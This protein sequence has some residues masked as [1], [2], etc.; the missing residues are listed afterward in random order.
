VEQN[1]TM[2]TLQPRR[3]G[4]RHAVFCTHPCEA[5][6][7]YY[8]RRLVPVLHGQIVDEATAVA[9][10]DIQWLP[11][12][13]RQ[14]AMILEVDDYSNVLQAVTIGYGRRYAEPDPLL[15]AADRARQQITLIT[16]TASAYTTVVND[17]T[18]YRT[19]LPCEARTYELT[20][21][22]PGGTGR[23]Q[24]GDFVQADPQH[25][26]QLVLIFDSEIA[27]AAQPTSGRQR[28]LI[29]HERTLYRNDDCSGPLP[30]AQGGALA[31]PYESYTLAFTPELVQAI[32]VDS[33]KLTAGEVDSVLAAEGGDVHSEGDA[34][35]WMPSGQVF[36]H[37]DPQAAPAQECAFAQQHFWLPQRFRDPFQHDALVRYDAYD[38]LVLETEDALQNTVTAGARDSQ[39]A[40]TN[41]NDYRLLQPA[42]LTD[43][44]GNQ[45][46]VAFDV[47][48]LVAG[49]AA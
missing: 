41:G 4:N 43:P 34:N 31:L 47:L 29:E 27:Y 10:P 33:Q 45:S 23:F 22:T 40:V 2:R 7:S 15:T 19:P 42:L 46:A 18:A 32:Y 44:N 6:T 37:P 5:T 11:D 12:P 49:S 25:P 36:F 17:G 24:A 30:F 28:R 3:A 9:H 8:E 13:G 1:F 39:G 38:L 26:P 35:W 21:Y 20:G 16:Y 14:H 48:G